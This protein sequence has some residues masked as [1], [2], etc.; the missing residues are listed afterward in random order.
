MPAGLTPCW[1]VENYIRIK[2][3]V[4]WQQSDVKQVG[5]ATTGPDNLKTQTGYLM[6]HSTSFSWYAFSD[7][8]I[9]EGARLVIR[10]ISK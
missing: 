1:R 2:V 3:V 4:S 10:W 7:L 8:L 6:N 5:A 9:S